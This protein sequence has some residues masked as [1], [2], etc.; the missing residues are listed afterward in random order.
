MLL[1]QANEI[2]CV[3][4]DDLMLW[5]CNT[6]CQSC[7]VHAFSVQSLLALDSA[8]S[9][10]LTTS[11]CCMQISRKLAHESGKQRITGKDS[12]A[13]KVFPG[14]DAAFFIAVCLIIDELFHD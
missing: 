6:L 8:T 3:L 9:P 5:Y 7:S 10:S 13:L 11:F 1:L 14:S 2:A 4:V 12:Y